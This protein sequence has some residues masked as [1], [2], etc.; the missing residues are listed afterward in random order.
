MTL[1]KPYPVQPPRSAFTLL[2]VILALAILAGSVAVLG[3]VM[4]LAGDSSRRAIAETRA[5]LIASTVFAQLR[6][7]ARE[8]VDAVD[9]PFEAEYPVGWLVSV[10]VTPIEGTVE[11]LNSVQ[12]TAAQDLEARLQPASYSL[13]VW[14]HTP[15]PSTEGSSSEGA[16]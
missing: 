13:T 8:L 14:M 2:E 7:G 5:Q 1:R 11:D 9:E 15:E 16:R 4:R 3:E 12:I 10:T 6:S